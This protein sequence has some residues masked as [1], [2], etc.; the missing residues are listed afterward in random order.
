MDFLNF[1]LMSVLS[2]LVMG[3]FMEHPVS[4]IIRASICITNHHHQPLNDVLENCN[5]R[6]ITPRLVNGEYR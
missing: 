3:P 5:I 2:V 1:E 4:G 6:K